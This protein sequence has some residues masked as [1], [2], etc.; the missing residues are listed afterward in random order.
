MAR[1]HD[2]SQVEDG[3]AMEAEETTEATEVETTEDAAKLA[4]FKAKKAEAA[5]RFKERRAEEK[6]EC[7]EKAKALIARMQETGIWSQLTTDEQNFVSHLANPAISGARVNTSIFTKLF[8]DN[9]S[10]GDSIT[11]AEAFDKTLKGKSAIDA[12]VKKWAESGIIVEFE[13]NA[14][15]VTDSRYV[16]KA[17]A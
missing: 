17:L 7:I 11:M 3:F 2:E 16:I 4:E 1:K 14:D 6:K 9:P 13:L 8:G 12:Y 10:V 5:K 15:K